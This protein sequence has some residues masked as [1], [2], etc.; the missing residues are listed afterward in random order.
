M[1][2]WQVARRQYQGENR[3]D[4]FAIRV[5]CCS[6]CGLIRS[7][8]AVVSP[9][10][11]HFSGVLLCL[12]RVAYSS[13]PLCYHLC[14]V[15]SFILAGASSSLCLLFAG[16]F[17]WISFFSSLNAFSL[18]LYCMYFHTF[19]SISSSS[20]ARSRRRRGSSVANCFDPIGHL[21]H[22]ADKASFDA[23]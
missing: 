16:G 10:G 13:F 19:H 8:L 7:S 21:W 12:F 15:R 2:P 4:G 22:S 20:H 23:V 11:R 1:C 5:K 18:F 14:F 6:R 17:A 9:A 3:D